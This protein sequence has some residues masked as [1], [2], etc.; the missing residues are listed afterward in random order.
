M[1]EVEG[2]KKG[3]ELNMV[4]TWIYPMTLN[5]REN[6]SNWEA[7]RE[8]VQNMMDASEN[9]FTIKQTSDGLLLKDAGTGLKK[10]H[11]LL[12][13]SEKENNSRGKFGEGLKLAL[14]VLKRLGYDV[15]I[16]S[17]NLKITVDTTI[18][19][20]EKCLKLL[21]DT[22]PNNVSGTE[23][24]IKGYNDSTFDDNFVKKNNK[25]VIYKC[26]KGQIIEE[27]PTRLYVKDIFVCDLENARYS[28]NLRNIQLAEDRNI[29]S[30]WDLRRCIGRVYEMVNKKQL[31]INLFNAIK[32]GQYEHNINI[33]YINGVQSKTW[34]NAFKE[35]YGNK[36]VIRTDDEW[37]REATWRGAKVVTIPDNMSELKTIIDTDKQFTLKDN[38]G[39]VKVKDSK[40]E[41]GELI[42]LKVLRKLSKKISPDVKVIATILDKPACYNIAKKEIMINRN[43]LQDLNKCLGSLVHELAHTRGASDMTAE[44]IHMIGGVAGDLLYPYVI[45]SVK[46]RYKRVAQKQE[47]D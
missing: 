25:K 21:I 15:I 47:G 31:L 9:N 11:L 1:V 44:M 5:Y 32:E 12:G 3:S 23:V 6:W 39:T 10:K 28:Y 36:A 13:V 22:T 35:V 4:D 2:V 37:E 46:K 26:P 40:L 29:P 16:K 34:V 20:E 17:N 43:Q 30:E 7:V 38:K 19:E 33:N 18:I 42:H 14:I 45:R 41:Q 24:L 27:T 8:I